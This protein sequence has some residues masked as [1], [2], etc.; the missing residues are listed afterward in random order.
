MAVERPNPRGGT[1]R[2][3]VQRLAPGPVEPRLLAP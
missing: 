2:W 1:L 3:T